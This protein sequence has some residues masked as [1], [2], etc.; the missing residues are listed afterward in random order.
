MQNQ[1]D[2]RRADAVE[3]GRHR[4]EITKVDV[5]RPQRGDDDEVREDEG[6]APR[7]GAPKAAAQLGNVDP[8]LDG[9]RPGQ[10]LTDRNRLA[11]W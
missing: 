1:R 4:L 3:D 11:H 6:P 9:E 10:R 2:H 5:K 8:D 7:P